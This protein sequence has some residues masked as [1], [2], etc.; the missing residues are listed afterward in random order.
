[1]LRLY[2]RVLAVV[3]ALAGGAILLG[4]FAVGVAVSALYLGLA[5]VVAWVSFLRKPEF[6]RAVVGGVGGIFLLSGLFLAVVV[7]ILG[8]PYQGTGWEMGLANA[9]LGASSMAC[10]VLLPCADED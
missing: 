9:A 1:M 7:S 10:A 4:V 6:L 2:A 8:F 3:L 5:A